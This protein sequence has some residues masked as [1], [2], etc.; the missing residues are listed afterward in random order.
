MGEVVVR[1]DRLFCTSNTVRRHVQ[2]GSVGSGGPQPA[3]IS[4]SIAEIPDM[5]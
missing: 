5:S 2:N 3:V 1:K 4:I